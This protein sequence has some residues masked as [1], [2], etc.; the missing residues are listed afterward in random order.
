MPKNISADCILDYVLLVLNYMNIFRTH[1]WRKSR[2]LKEYSRSY[3]T[4]LEIL[5]FILTSAFHSRHNFFLPPCNSE[6]SE[7]QHKLSV[8]P[9]KIE[10]LLMNLKNTFFRLWKWIYHNF[11]LHICLKT[12]PEIKH[13]WISFIYISAS[14]QG[15]KALLQGKEKYKVE[16]KWDSHQWQ[17][18][19]RQYSLMHFI[20]KWEEKKCVSFLLLK[21][22]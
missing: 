21:F 17:K 6:H 8:Y 7:T 19:G 11:L 1:E 3:W 13:A 9:S 16:N 4:C 20:L 5:V 10:S 22:Q 15:H 12:F 2:K 18:E 14:R